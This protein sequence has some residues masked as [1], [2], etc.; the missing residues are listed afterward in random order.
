MCEK[1]LGECF[2]LTTLHRLPSHA[3]VFTVSFRSLDFFYDGI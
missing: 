1:R 3:S 2:V